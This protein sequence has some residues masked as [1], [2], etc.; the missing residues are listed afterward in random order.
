[1]TKIRPPP[2][3]S[4]IPLACLHLPRTHAPD[5]AHINMGLKP[6]FSVIL[7]GN[8]MVKVLLNL[9]YGII[10]WALSVRWVLVH[11]TRLCAYG[12]DFGLSYLFPVSLLIS[13][14]SSCVEEGAPE[15]P[16]CLPTNCPEISNTSHFWNIVLFSFCEC[17]ESINQAIPTK[18]N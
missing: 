10:L 8:L 2:S 16:K 13:A 14:Q 11:D 12:T 3:C 5:E 18:C 15:G 7:S 6:L 1:M 9:C 4:Y 17:Q